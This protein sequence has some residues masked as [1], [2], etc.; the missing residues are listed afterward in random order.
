[1]FDA[2]NPDS[3]AFWYRLGT[4]ILCG[5]IIGLERQLRGKAAGIRTSILICLGTVTYIRLGILIGGDHQDPTRTLGQVITGVG[6][7][8]VV[9]D[10]AEEF[11]GASGN[12]FE[13]KSAGAGGS[14]G[15]NDEDE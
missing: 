2:L 14:A 8:D 7:F 4:A 13:R 9:G 15:S 10:G 12:L 6:F 5:G 3:P 1:M 11:L